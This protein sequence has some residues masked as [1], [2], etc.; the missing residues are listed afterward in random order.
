MKKTFNPRPFLETFEARLMFAVQALPIYINAGGTA[1][2]DSIARPFASST[3]F[4][5]GSSGSGLFD[6]GNDA[7]N[8][9]FDV[10]EHGPQVSFATPVADGHYAVW[11]EF[12][13]TLSTAAGQNVM[14]VSVENQPVLSG[15]DVAAAAGLDTPTAKEFD[16]D[17]TNG[18]LNFNLSAVTGDAFVNAVVAIPSDVPV[19]AQPYSWE[20]LGGDANRQVTAASN[21]SQLG[22]A[23]ELYQNENRGHDPADLATLYETIGGPISA[24]ADPR[25]DTLLPRGELSPVESA[26]WVAA[27]N[28]FMYVGAPLKSSSPATAVAAYENPQRVAGG[29][30]VLYADGHVAFLSRAEA[31]A[32]LGF[33]PNVAPTGGAP[34]QSSVPADTRVLQSAQN[35]QDI[36][37]TMES[38]ANDN[39]GQFPTSPGDLVDYGAS[40]SWFVDP[41]GSTPPPASGLTGN[42]AAAYINAAIDYTYLAAGKHSSAPAEE[43]LMY[44]KPSTNADGLLLLFADGSTQFEETRWAMETL[45]RSAQ[46]YG[47]TTPLAEIAEPAALVVGQSE[48]LDGAG[49]PATRLVSNAQSVRPFATYQWDFD[50][51][52]NPADFSVD[53]TGEAPTFTAATVPASGRQT[54]ALR[55]VDVDGYDSAITTAVVSVNP[56]APVLNGGVL[57]VTGTSGRDM[58]SISPDGS[59]HV[60]VTLDGV[61]TTFAAA[62]ISNIDVDTDGGGDGITIM[63]MIGDGSFDGTSAP[64]V[65]VNATGSSLTFDTSV[66]A[67]SVQILDSTG[68]P[69]I[70]DAGTT[71]FVANANSIFVQGEAGNDVLDARG[72]HGSSADAAGIV[73]SGG[74]G[75][76][77]L[78]GSDSNAPG[79]GTLIL[80]GGDGDDTFYAVDGHVESISGGAGNDRAACDSNDTVIDV[81][82]PLNS[83]IA[84]TVFDDANGNGKL[85]SGEAG[86]ANVELYNDANN[87]GV[88]DGGE[89]TTFT[90]AAGAYAFTALSAGNYKIRELVGSGSTQT[91]PSNNFGWTVTLKA[92]QA[93]TGDNFGQKSATPA[94]GSISGTVAGG[95]AG[96]TIYLDANNDSKFDAGELSTTTSASGTYSFS[97]V[98]VGATI[99]RQVLPS[100]YTQTTPS[101]G[102]GIHVTVTQGG[103]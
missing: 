30:N 4:T 48:L 28:D 31:G 44:E 39:R 51:D 58:L 29:L 47:P 74:G 37:A 95:R 86:L 56:P 53:A 19:V 14:N 65:D 73:L 70:L 25:T 16:V 102:L 88:L 22:R 62:Q 35:L 18:S 81:E 69:L 67:D 100:G 75:N 87:N 42:A 27:R 66:A 8:Q 97:N 59:G 13:D 76:D 50:Y 68:A 21:L 90:T 32:T 15:F 84:G 23:V 45:R 5:A 6:F 38:Y 82:T 3:G 2:V 24:Y 1:V 12:A 26:A 83:S 78:Y 57:T 55:V 64:T 43:V 77:T 61:T 85:D 46:G 103:S 34:V 17:V 20:G 92:N 36:A 41:R 99:I 40:P 94:G 33:D 89:L 91:T 79:V 98:P 96:E 101:G 54:I 71:L 52:G 63:S 60:V 7:G 49:I 9:L 72:Y 93:V 10:Y 80:N 11:L